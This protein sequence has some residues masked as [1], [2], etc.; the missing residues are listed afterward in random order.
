LE[1]AKAKMSTDET[2]K[3]IRVAQANKEEASW[4][5]KEESLY[6]QFLIR[7]TAAKVLRLHSR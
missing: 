2:V 4:R 3:A 7:K 6:P 5:I 1:I